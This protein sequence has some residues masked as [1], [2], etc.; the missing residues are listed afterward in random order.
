MDIF[1]KIINKEIKSDIYYEDDM[2]IAIMDIK[3][4][5]PGHFLVI[6]KNYSKNL[7]DISNDEMTYLFLKSRELAI[8][9]INELKVSGF[10]LIVN[11]GEEA[12]QEI[13]R[14]HVHI[15]PSLK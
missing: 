10:N 11:N 14:T 5:N 15:I 4:K 7:I 13:F 2:I 3:P 6:P 12:G 9:K 1:Q 8:K